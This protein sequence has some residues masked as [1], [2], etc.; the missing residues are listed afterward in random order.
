MARSPVITQ[1][2]ITESR[3]DHQKT[4][5]KA[6]GESDQL[7]GMVNGLTIESQSWTLKRRRVSCEHP[8]T[9]CMWTGQKTMG[10]NAQC[11]KVG[12]LLKQNKCAQRLDN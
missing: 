1:P 7:L 2:G 12:P 4:V 10:L 5:G 9:G 3:L 11:N 6:E 8:Y